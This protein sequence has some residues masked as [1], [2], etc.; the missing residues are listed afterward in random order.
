MSAEGL[1]TI[2]FAQ[3]E[4]DHGGIQVS[5][6][7]TRGGTLFLTNNRIYGGGVSFYFVGTYEE[8]DS[9]ISMTIN[10]T[11]YNDIVSG[12]FGTANEARLIFNGRIEGDEM[13]LSGNLED[14]ANKKM[15]VKATRRAVVA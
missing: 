13:M 15:D 7:V 4:E 2:Q 8:S 12:I 5:E 9:G 3:A 6:D 1:W 11:R 10:V 14:E